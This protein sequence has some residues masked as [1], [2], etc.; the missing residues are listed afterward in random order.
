MTDESSSGVVRL[1]ISCDGSVKDDLQVLS[2]T[3]RHALN[4]IPWARLVLADGEMPTNESPLS[5]SEQF[6]PGAEIVISA[7]Y[8]DDETPIFSGIVVRHGYKISGNNFSR[9]IVECRDKACKMTLGR[10]NAHFVDQ[11]DSAIIQ[12]LIGDAGLEA[13]VE[14]TS[15][16]HKELSQYYCS[17]WDFML[18]RAELMG[19]LVNVEAG[20]VSV[21]APSFGAPVLTLTWGDNL[22]ELHAD[23]DARSQWKQ[24]QAQGWDPAQ[25]A[26]V[27]G[28][29]EAPPTLNSQGNLDGSTL[30]AIASPETLTLQS[31]SVADTELLNSWAKAVQLRAG[32]ARIRGRLSFQGSELAKP[33]CLITLAG[34]GTRFNG[35]VFVSAVQHELADGNWTSEAEFGLDPNWHVERPDVM[36]PHNGGHSPGVRGLQI[37]V[38]LKLDEDPASQSRIQIKLPSLAN[39]TEGIWARLLQLHASNGFGAFFLPEVN[40]EVLVGYLDADPS[41]PVVLGSLYSSKQLAPYA[42]EAANNTKALV[43]RCKHR[44]EF[45]EED[46][47][48][49]LTTPAA[50]QLVLDDKN[51]S[52]TVQDENGNSIKLEQG[53][54]T[55]S[56]PKDIK[57]SA[58]GGITLDAVGAISLSSKADIKHSGMNISSEAQIAYSAKGN[59][60]A[61]LSASGQTT[62]K[63]ALVMIN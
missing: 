19:M 20:K 26:L 15:F 4:A 11:T 59:A 24:V 5:D 27:Q 55:L 45:N 7:G 30:A 54:I 61:E 46:K 40:D 57:L 18:A 25:Q 6:K 33:G 17:D 53:G 48:I 52:I 43:T 14:G 31:P 56:S 10:K 13:S 21:A 34:V 3:V 9:L 38:V 23:I 60:S 47:I 16:Q 49:T 29:A 1:S 28:S 2:C 22:I 35:D 62:V 41:C 42:F 39:S 12:T 58:K 50:N 8:G 63:G 37:G 32:L 36:A 51:K 44:F